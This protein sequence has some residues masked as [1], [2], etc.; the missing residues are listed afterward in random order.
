MILQGKDELGG[1]G[2]GDVLDMSFRLSAGSLPVEHAHSLYRAL[3]RA[4]PWLADEP[5]AGIHGIRVAESGHGWLRPDASRGEVLSVSRR[6]RLTLRLPRERV[7]QAESLCGA[8]LDVDGHSFVVGQAK[9]RRLDP[10][11][12]LFS[13]Y[14][15]GDEGQSEEEFV[16]WAAQTLENMGIPPR[17]LLCGMSNVI[18]TPARRYFTR[19]LMVASLSADDSLDLQQR[20]LGAGRLMGCGLF[21]PHKGIEAIR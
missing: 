14:V 2:P 9:L 20:G 18:A 17:E 15:M 19:S 13:R 12:T 10:C 16:A 1:A 6:T 3:E 11:A 7:P 4:L 21:V 5:R 8:T